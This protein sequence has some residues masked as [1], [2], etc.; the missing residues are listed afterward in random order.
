MSDIKLK[1]NARTATG[2]KAAALRANGIIPSVV[3]GEGE[4]ILAQ[5]AY[6]EVEKALT[7]AGYHSTID[8]D[9]DGKKKMVIVKDV[10]VNPVSRK[11]VNVEFQAVAANQAI[12]ATTPIVIEGFETS[13]ASKAHFALLQV[14]EEIEVKAKPSDLPKELTID[15]SKMAT[16]EDKLTVA[17]IV[18]PK[19]VEFADKELDSASAIAILTDPAAEAAAREAEDAAA[20][21][22]GETAAADVPSDNGSKPEEAAE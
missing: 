15:G 17:D 3:Y 19:G 2:K 6:N 16:L 20:K 21:E 14:M 4:P 5:G 8:V 9:F 1:L 7:L 13:D 22:A 11:I 18:L 12:E 10:N